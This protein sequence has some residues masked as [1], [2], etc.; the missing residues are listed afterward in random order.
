MPNS[1]IYH[2]APVSEL[3]SGLTEVSYKPQRFALDGFVH[4]AETPVTTVAVAN[5]YFAS[6]KEPLAVLEID[7]LRLTAPLKFE[8]PAPLP[9][10]DAHLKMASLFPHIYGPID[11]GAIQSA[12]LLVR[13]NNHYVWPSAFHSL[14]NFME[15]HGATG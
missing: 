10:G 5:D 9:G 12:A 13:M 11:V 2:L 15:Q 14:P 8:A 3:Q 7:P 1:R 6:L 4:C